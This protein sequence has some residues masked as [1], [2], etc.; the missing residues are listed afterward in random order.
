MLSRL[1]WAVLKAKHSKG[2]TLEQWRELH[3]IESRVTRM[4]R[5]V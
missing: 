1:Q 3:H 5:S 2:I 4:L